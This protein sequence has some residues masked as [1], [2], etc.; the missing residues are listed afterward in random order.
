MRVDTWEDGTPE[1]WQD[2]L[3]I[4]KDWAG[5]RK[6]VRASI[7]DL[8]CWSLGVSMEEL[9]QLSDEHPL[10]EE[11]SH[12]TFLCGRENYP[13]GRLPSTGILY[14][15]ET[16]SVEAFAKLAN[17]EKWELKHWNNSDADKTAVKRQKIK[18]PVQQKRDSRLKTES[19]RIANY[20]L[21]EY[22]QAQEDKPQLKVE[23][24]VR[25]KLADINAWAYKQGFVTT[26]SQSKQL[27]NN[28]RKLIKAKEKA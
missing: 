25:H 11:F 9:N 2:D 7:D 27:A 28:V 5:I 16:V 24:F 17:E 4:H 18:E 1:D 21:G 13:A 15:E 6:L 3:P 22:L 8:I 19:L 23:A 12:R 26:Y 20:A 10:A 14:G